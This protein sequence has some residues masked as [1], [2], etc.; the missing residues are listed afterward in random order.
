MCIQTPNQW[1]LE[2]SVGEH[3]E[4]LGGGGEGMEALC[5]TSTNTPHSPP[6]PAS[7]FPYA[8]LPFV[9]S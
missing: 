8:S 6:P 9:Y 7:T 1:G 4:V 2:N 3:V 5:S